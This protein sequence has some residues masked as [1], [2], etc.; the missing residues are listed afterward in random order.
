MFKATY[1]QLHHD[2]LTLFMFVK[3]LISLW[4]IFL[5]I[6]RVR[7]KL[8]FG[9]VNILPTAL[10]VLVLVQWSVCCSLWLCMPQS[11]KIKQC[12]LE[13]VIEETRWC[14]ALDHSHSPWLQPCP[15]TNTLILFSVF[16]Q[17]GSSLIL[18]VHSFVQSLTDGF[19]K[20]DA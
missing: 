12:L 13:W 18:L 5:Y 3:M 7:L 8:N 15:A 11:E 20:E 19:Y 6:L 14:A 2:I 1:S 9:M 17:F 16:Q 4:I 10:S